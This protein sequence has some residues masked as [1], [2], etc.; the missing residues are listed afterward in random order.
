MR[1]HPTKGGSGSR[2]FQLDPRVDLRGRAGPE[3]DSEGEEEFQD[4][5][6]EQPLRS[7]CRATSSSNSGLGWVS[8]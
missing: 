2:E 7:L 8:L 5:R 4:S 3:S 6:E 1:S